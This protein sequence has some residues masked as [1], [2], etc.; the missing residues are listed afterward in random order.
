MADEVQA[1]EQGA[2]SAPLVI[3]PIPDGYRSSNDGKY[4]TLSNFSNDEDTEAEKKA[5]ADVK[6]AASKLGKKGGKASAEKREAKSEETV[7]PPKK[8]KDDARG[9]GKAAAGG[10]DEPE[11]GDGEG[12]EAS[13]GDAEKPLGKPDRDP[14]ARVAEATREARE[15]REEARRAR[16][17][18]RQAAWERDQL[19]Q[20]RERAAQPEQPKEPDRSVRP[21]LE[22]FESYEEYTEALTDWKVEQKFR[23]VEE[24]QQEQAIIHGWAEKTT[25]ALKSFEKVMQEA[26]EADPDWSTRVDPQ[27]WQAFKPAAFL[28]PNEPV[29]PHNVIFQ[30]MH[31]SPMAPALFAYFSDDAGKKEFSRIARLR[32]PREISMELARLEERLRPATAGT[33]PETSVSK[34]PLPFQ[35]VKGAPHT[36]EQP[37]RDEDS[38]DSYRASAKKSA[39]R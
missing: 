10:V 2:P 15:A 27:L 21:K 1:P 39:T 30:E 9:A 37:Y 4:E 13:G 31:D 29:R 7:E 12:A 8:A 11:V 18:A 14:R 19:R 38:Y 34:A 35:P 3:A 24:T 5:E 26:D 6:D 32:T 25:N 22:D 23:H 20:E 33:R 17:E 36:G 28:H 16:E